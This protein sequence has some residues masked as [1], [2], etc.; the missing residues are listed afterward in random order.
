MLEPCPHG[1]EGEVHGGG[2]GEEGGARD[3]H[4]R[5]G[6]HHTQAQP[7][8]I[9]SE[10]AQNTTVKINLGNIFNS[11][12]LYYFCSFTSHRAQIRPNK[13]LRK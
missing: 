7:T 5:T 11:Q 2:G 9:G 3:E 10:L 8:N 12:L 13:N 6:H 4:P 1:E